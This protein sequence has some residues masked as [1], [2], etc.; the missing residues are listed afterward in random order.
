MKRKNFCNIKIQ[1]TMI[2]KFKMNDLDAVMQIWL[3]ANM[4]THYFIKNS[5]WQENYEMVRKILPSATIFVYEEEN[6]IIGFI[7]LMDSMIAGLFIRENFQSKGIG[8]ALLDYV[9][10]NYCELMLQV[11]KKNVRALK[12]Y[13]RENFVVMKEQMDINVMESEL[14][15]NWKKI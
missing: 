7:G 6:S 14:I 9:K 1:D 11:Y 13:E 15:M 3:T 2:R 5:Y 4:Q 12:F 8:K 10:E